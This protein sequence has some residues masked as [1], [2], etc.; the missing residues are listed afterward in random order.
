MNQNTPNPGTPDNNDENNPLTG[1]ESV[2]PAVN[3]AT[4]NPYPV[5]GQPNQ[6]PLNVTERKP[7]K[8]GLWA[9]IGLVVVAIIIAIIFFFLNQKD[10]RIDEAQGFQEQMQEVATKGGVE[11]C[12]KYSDTLLEQGASEEELRKK[13]S[14]ETKQNFNDSQVFICSNLDLTSMDAIMQ[15]DPSNIPE[16]MVGFYNGENVE[17]K[18][19]FKSPENF[20]DQ[21][22]WALAGDNWSLMGKN[23]SAED[24]QKIMG[25]DIKWKK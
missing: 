20:S 4:N 15:A 12:S 21:L 22:S 16:M 24:A 13:I 23:P 5:M 9:V 11:H 19:D 25:G 8:V 14:E 6:P 2:D 7:S 17:W 1:N 18:D 10:S 3:D